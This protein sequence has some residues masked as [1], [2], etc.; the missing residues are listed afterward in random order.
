MKK[1]GEDKSS[2]RIVYVSALMAMA[3][4]LMAA[5][6]FYIQVLKHDEFLTRA[7]AQYERF[8]LI[9]PQRGTIFDRNMKELAMSIE[10]DSLYLNP[11][12]IEQPRETVKKLSKIVNTDKSKLLKNIKE[13]RNFVWVKRKIG[14]RQARRIKESDIEGTGFI[15]EHKRFYPKKSLAGHVIGFVGTDNKGLEGLEYF[16]DQSL[17]G[18]SMQILIERDALGR[19]IYSDIDSKFPLIGYDLILTIDEVI[20]YIAE[21]ELRRQIIETEAKGG[22]II[23]MEPH[24]G[25]VLALAEF[26]SFNLNNFAEYDPDVWRNRAVTDGYEPG[27]T[28]KIIEAAAALE[29]GRAKREKLIFCEN[30]KIEVGGVTIRDHEKYGWLTFEEVVK[31]SSNIGAIKIS[32]GL[33][34]KVFYD[35]IKRFGFG[36]K[37]GID[38]PGEVPGLVRP[39]K[40]WSRVSVG[41]ISIGQEILVTPVQLINAMSAIANGGILVKPRVLKAVSYRGSILKETE[42]EEI[43][44]VI[45]H[46]TSR[47]MVRILKGVVKEGTGNLAAVSGFSVA[48]KTGTAQKF[49]KKLKAYSED[50]YLASF[51][52]FVPAENPQL[53]ILVIIDEPKDIFW[54]GRVAAPVFS[55]VAGET[56]RYLRIPPKKHTLHVRYDKGIRDEAVQEE[57]VQGKPFFADISGSILSTLRGFINFGKEKIVYQSKK[58]RESG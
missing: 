13:N 25:E 50:K 36:E 28:F 43:R 44:R 55:R 32:Q 41:A 8:L 53:T 10:I 5:R 19:D 56:L 51:V 2:M 48:G 18:E 6:L 40:E 58:D 16:H 29:E 9:E 52:G 22:M 35:Y 17:R 54:G 24:S 33:G 47:E 30:G 23:V 34:E 3:F 1:R 20:Q 39:L 7:K 31:K 46:D 26:P 42:R 15:K 14:P 4:L 37:T 57:D 21:K 12:E 27:S 49:D 38:L 11:K 45:S